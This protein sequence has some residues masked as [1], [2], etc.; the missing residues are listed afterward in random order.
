M[1]S[2]E[3]LS[4]MLMALYNHLTILLQCKTSIVPYCL[5]WPVVCTIVYILDVRHADN[6]QDL[7]SVLWHCWL[8]IRKTIQSVKNEWWG[9][10]MV[11]CL[12]R[13]ACM[14]CIWSSWCHCHPIISCFIKIQIGFW[15]RLMQVVLE[16]RLLSGCL[17]TCRMKY[18]LT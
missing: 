12:E 9:V 6:V 14:I 8:V 11:I 13:G 15:S 17:V 16:N 3:N 7:P 18:W 1:L 4:Q 5:Q 10:G 2:T